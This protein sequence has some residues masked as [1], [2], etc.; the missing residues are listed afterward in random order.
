MAVTSNRTTK[1]VMSGDLTFNYEEVIQNSA[2]PGDVDIMTL[3]SGSNTITLPTGGT[4][5]KA[6]TIVP[7][8][9]NTATLTIKGVTGDT[10]VAISKTEPTTIAFD[11]PPPTNFVITTSAIVTGLRI[12]WS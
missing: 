3:S 4:T 11:S 8:D 9:A 7:P 12:I 5:I 6:A 2:A 10:G 1:V